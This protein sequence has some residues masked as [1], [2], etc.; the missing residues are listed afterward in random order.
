MRPKRAAAVRASACLLEALVEEGDEKACPFLTVSEAAALVFLEQKSPEESILVVSGSGISVAS[1]LSTFQSTLEKDGKRATGGRATGGLYE[2]A[3]KRFK[4][5]EGMELFH[6]KFYAE[7]PYDAL[8]FLGEMCEQAKRC[9]PTRTHVALKALEDS[10]KMVRHYTMNIDGLHAKAGMSTWRNDDDDG[11]TVE[12]HGTLFDLVDTE[13]GRV[14]DVDDEALAKIK[15]KKPAFST[16]NNSRQAK[17][18]ID[19]EDDNQDDDD[20]NQEANEAR[21]IRFRVMFYGD[22]EHACIL[23]AKKTLARLR[24]DAKQA[25]IVLWLGISFQQY[26]SCDYLRRV[27]DA[28]K[29]QTLHLILNPSPD[30]AYHARASLGDNKNN[31]DLRACY[32]TSDELFDAIDQLQQQEKITQLNTTT[33]LTEDNPTIFAPKAQ[34]DHDI[35]YS[36]STKRKQQQ[37]TTP[38]QQEAP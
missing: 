2:R 5:K 19:L 31:V 25:N 36:P 10:G 37:T 35:I 7:R 24:D 13:T 15:R 20:E 29:P 21:R 12:L 4:L 28:A 34:D 33:F 22:A 18:T 3:R 38:G 1:G 23:D 14:Y 30:A 27:T 8:Q 17:R 26:A 11:K 9:V 32:A 16:E 6:W